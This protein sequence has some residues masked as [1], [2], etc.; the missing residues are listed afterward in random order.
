VVSPQQACVF[1]EAGLDRVPGTFLWAI[2]AGH[3]RL[4]RPLV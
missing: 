4:R 3:G 2:D 1:G